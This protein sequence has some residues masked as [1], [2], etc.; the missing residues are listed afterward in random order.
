[1]KTRSFIGKKTACV[2]T[3]NGDC[4]AGLAFRDGRWWL[5]IGPTI[6]V[7]PNGTFN[8]GTTDMEIDITELVERS[9]SAP[10]P[11]RT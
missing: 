6:A 2:L 10:S 11:G 4:W 9:W 3:E 7:F 5:S 1:M 8:G